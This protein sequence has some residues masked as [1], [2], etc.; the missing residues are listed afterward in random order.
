MKNGRCFPAAWGLAYKSMEE[1]MV[2]VRARR[3]EIGCPILEDRS[4][5]VAR[6][7]VELAESK[8]AGE[9]IARALNNWPETLLPTVRV[10]T[11]AV[12]E[13]EDLVIVANALDCVIGVH[14]DACTDKPM[15]INAPTAENPKRHSKALN[16][17]F[18][19]TEN[20]RVGH[21]A[22]LRSVPDYRL[23]ALCKATR[24]IIWLT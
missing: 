24:D 14:F 7:D 21:W 17:I 9:Q 11:G 16:L 13:E 12:M 19:K 20:P 6:H 10:E 8:Q 5:D 2:Q 18:E 22:L 23:R 4:I 3:N 15:Y 1:L